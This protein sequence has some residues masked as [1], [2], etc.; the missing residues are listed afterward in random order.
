[1]GCAVLKHA[2]LRLYDAAQ[3]KKESITL[4][5]KVKKEKPC[6]VSSMVF[7]VLHYVAYTV[8]TPRPRAIAMIATITAI[9]Q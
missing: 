4:Y 8:T 9:R 1:M 6:C 5:R 2:I 7:Y 3:R